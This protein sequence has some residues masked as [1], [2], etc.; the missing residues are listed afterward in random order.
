LPQDVPPDELAKVDNTINASDDEMASDA[1]E[2]LRRELTAAL[3]S[4][5]AEDDEDD[6]YMLGG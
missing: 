1:I 4:A 2:M 5:R 6:D 3:N